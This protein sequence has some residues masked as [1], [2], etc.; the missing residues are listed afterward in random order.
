MIEVQEEASNTNLLEAIR[1]EGLDAYGSIIEAEWVRKKLGIVI[2]SVG[3]KREFDAAAIAEL[4]AVDR[5]RQVLLNEGKYLGMRDG[6][7][8]IFL[9]S[10]NARQ[11]EAYMQQ[12]DKKLKRGLK[13]S[14]S[15]PVD[16]SHPVSDLN[17]RL[18]MKQESIRKHLATQASSAVI[19]DA[20]HHLQAMQTTTNEPTEQN[21]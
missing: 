4:S 20:T 21:A 17:V 15:T 11:V 7:Y 14:K 12:A 1:S 3:T 13:L 10:E 8:R 9:P 16:A 19:A 18:I 2:P 6:N 5:V